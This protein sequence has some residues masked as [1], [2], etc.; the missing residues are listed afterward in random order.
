[1]SS[2]NP[3]SLV[4]TPHKKKTLELT[5]WEIDETFMPN[6]SALFFSWSTFTFNRDKHDD[7]V[8]FLSQMEQ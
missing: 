8:S 4:Y 3:D 6:L 2:M 7:S 1:M 5:F